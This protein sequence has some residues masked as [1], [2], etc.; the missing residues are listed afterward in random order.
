[1]KPHKCPICDGKGIVSAGFYFPSRTGLSDKTSETCIQC[2]GSGIIWSSE[3]ILEY[4][5]IDTSEGQLIVKI[6]NNNNEIEKLKKEIREL[7][8]KIR[9]YQSLIL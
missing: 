9:I 5:I 3:E 2:S 8:N 4:E 7:K 1:M 6:P